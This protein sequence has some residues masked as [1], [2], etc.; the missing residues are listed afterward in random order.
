MVMSVAPD[1]PGAVAGV[2]QG[3]VILS[4]DGEAISSVQQVLRALG[5]SR[6][7]KTVHAGLRR[8]GQELDISLT[9]GER[10]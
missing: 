7:G 8:G 2:H 4:W 10:P 5:P 6:V 3:D 1:G 9:I